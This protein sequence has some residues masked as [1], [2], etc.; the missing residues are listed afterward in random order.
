VLPFSPTGVCVCC[1]LLIKHLCEAEI[2][3]IEDG[4]L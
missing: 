3:K 2:Y 4:V 1:V